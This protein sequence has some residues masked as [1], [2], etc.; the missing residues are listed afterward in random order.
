MTPA[1]YAGLQSPIAANLSSWFGGGPVYTGPTSAGAPLTATGVTNPSTY[2]A[3]ITGNESSLLSQIMGMGNNGA[4]TL[5]GTAGNYLGSVLQPNYVPNII[6]SPTVQA[7]MSAAIRPLQASYQDVTLPNLK[8]Q[9]VSN[10]AV[11][12]GPAQPGTTGNGAGSSAFDKAAAEAQTG[13]LNAEGQATGQIANEALQTGMNQQTQA[14]TQAPALQTSE[15]NNLIS[16]LQA[17]AL[18]RLIQ[19]YGMDAGLQQ[20]N[21]RVNSMLEALGIGAQISGPDTA[22]SGQSS[23]TFASQGG[24]GAMGFANQAAGL[25]GIGAPGQAMGK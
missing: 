25:A 12:N 17:E 13:L 23:Q 21:N 19:Q 11:L 16:S 8:S 2:S 5:N 10:G 18:P 20:F 15:L 1:A 6:N 9:F 7:A 4:G 3:P 14:A 22:Q 24:S